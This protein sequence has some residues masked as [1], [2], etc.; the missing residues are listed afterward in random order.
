MNNAVTK[1][2]TLPSAV[3]ALSFEEAMAEL[4]K[5]VRNLEEGKTRLDDAVKAY[6]RGAALKRHCENK[7]REAQLV[8]E[9]ISLNGDGSVTVE[10]M[11]YTNGSN[12]NPS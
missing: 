6:E 7:L 4:E 2:E 9:K 11:D 5:I 3:H 1:L 8:V 12:F 10:K